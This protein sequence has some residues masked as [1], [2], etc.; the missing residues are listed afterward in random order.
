MIKREFLKESRVFL[1]MP[2]PW[3]IHEFTITGN[4]SKRLISESLSAAFKDNS[5]YGVRV[6]MDPKSGSA[7]VFADEAMSPPITW[8]KEFQNLNNARSAELLENK[9]L[10][11]ADIF[12]IKKNQT[13]IRLYVHHVVCDGKGGLILVNDFIKE[14]NARIKKEEVNLSKEVTSVTEYNPF[15]KGG[16]TLSFATKLF[17][18]YFNSKV[19]S[20]RPEL[21]YDDM[22][23][24]QKKTFLEEGF[25]CKKI[26]FSEEA[27]ANIVK[28]AKNKGVSVTAFLLEK[29]SASYDFDKIEASISIDGRRY[30]DLPENSL[31]LPVKENRSNF[32]TGGKIIIDRSRY[33]NEED[34]LQYITS[35]LKTITEVKNATQM[36]KV[37]GNMNLAPIDI[38]DKKYA[39]IP[40][41][42]EEK[43]I[44]KAISNALGFEMK[45]NGF[46]LA[47][48]GKIE[49][50]PTDK[51]YSIDSYQLIQNTTNIYPIKYG[52]QTFKNVMS[53]FITY[54]PSL[55]DQN[56][57]RKIEKNI[58]ASV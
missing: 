10:V 4:V 25:A 48:F 40:M 57:I 58:K 33:S 50:Q 44:N 31:L 2:N 15:M 41:T 13:F 38:T 26:E 32:A 49:F 46:D 21:S 6:S 51:K 3:L 17:I 18:K 39:N 7:Y 27:T 45:R 28:K 19:A 23:K 11:Y 14:L 47:S 24:L 35:Q 12:R 53:I 42:T 52:I 56:Y 54:K 9:H 43:K 16:C 8:F 36:M 22:L 55:V 5:L 20:K 1:S 30:Y 29:I 37:F 34:R